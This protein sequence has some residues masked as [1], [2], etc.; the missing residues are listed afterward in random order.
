MKRVLLITIAFIMLM[1][2]LVGCAD[3]EHEH[4]DDYENFH[5]ALTGEIDLYDGEYDLTIASLAQMRTQVSVAISEFEKIYGLKVK[6]I[7]FDLEKGEFYMLD[8]KLMAGDT[9]IDVFFSAGLDMFKYIQKGCFVD[10]S[11]YDSLRTRIESNGYTNRTCRYEDKLFGISTWP[12]TSNEISSAWIY[13]IK[14]VNL[15]KESYTDVDG[16]EFFELLKIYYNNQDDYYGGNLYDRNEYYCILDEYFLI[17]PYSQ[18]KDT[19]VLL[20]EVVFDYLNGTHQSVRANGLTAEPERAYPQNADMSNTYFYFEHIDSDSF[21]EPL[22]DAYD[23]V[24]T[25]DGSDEALRKL[26]KDAAR[27]VRQRLEG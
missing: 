22:W 15:I 3:G 25:T 8:T 16:D 26:A 24:P 27:E 20:L 7:E 4:S 2:M 23:A 10:L 12:F 14:H 5:D 19:A 17:S 18:N 6:I 13:M 11:Q 9:D 21:I 1:L